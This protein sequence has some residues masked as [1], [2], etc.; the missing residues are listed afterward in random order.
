MAKE[1]KITAKFFPR[2]SRS[3]DNMYSLYFGLTYNRKSTTIS[4]N[5]DIEAKSKEEAEKKVQELTFKNP[6]TVEDIKDLIRM[7]IDL[8]G[9]ENNYSISGFSER[10]FFYHINLYEFLS[11]KLIDEFLFTIEDVISYRKY[12]ELRRYMKGI[13]EDSKN[14]EI[15][16]WSTHF[17]YSN[18]Q[19]DINSYID[20][21]LYNLYLASY[22]ILDC[23]ARNSEEVYYHI[24]KEEKDDLEYEKEV[25]S[26]KDW[27]MNSLIPTKSKGDYLERVGVKTTYSQYL[28]KV[29]TDKI[30]LFNINFEGLNYKPNLKKLLQLVD[31]IIKKEIKNQFK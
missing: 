18:Y 7:E 25:P 19:I 23:Y 16:S 15:F 8:I 21:N 26:I 5:K 3:K 22:T 10:Y 31:R 30:A 28:N 27:I 9:E 29:E 24:N 2:K 13:S 14:D 17:L 4:L 11:N 1:K 6:F 12:K 20:E